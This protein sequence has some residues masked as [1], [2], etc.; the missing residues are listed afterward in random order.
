MIIWKPLVAQLF[1]LVGEPVNE[2]D[3]NVVERGGW[4]CPTEISM[5][6]SIPYSTL[7]MIATG[8]LVNCE[9]E[10]GNAC[11]FSFLST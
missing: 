8:K 1:S 11:Q 4:L 3:K 9:G 6:I 10:S 2:V 7:G 5:F